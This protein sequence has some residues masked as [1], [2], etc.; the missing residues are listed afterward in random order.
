MWVFGGEFKLSTRKRTSFVASL[1]PKNDFFLPFKSQLWPTSRFSVYFSHL[2]GDYDC[3]TTIQS[4][5]RRPFQ[6]CVYRCGRGVLAGLLSR[7]DKSWHF[8]SSAHFCGWW[9]VKFWAKPDPF[10]LQKTKSKNEMASHHPVHVL[11]LVDA[12]LPF[13]GYTH[14]SPKQ[15]EKMTY[16][17]CFP[18]VSTGN[19]NTH[20][21][22]H[23]HAHTH[24]RA[25]VPWHMHFDLGPEPGRLRQVQI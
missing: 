9:R 17:K 15:M 4:A 20:A 14:D 10:P 11:S 12:V 18:T 1:Q 22:T 13:V 2:V 7:E 23:V 16:A 24:A 6:P 8:R 19:L 25:R 3:C 5:M 21:R